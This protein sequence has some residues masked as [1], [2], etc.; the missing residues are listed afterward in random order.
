M[1]IIRYCIFY[2]LFDDI[3]YTHDVYENQTKRN[4]GQYGKDSIDW[5]FVG[6]C[7]FSSLDIGAVHFY[8]LCV[9]FIHFQKKNIKVVPMFVIEY[10]LC[11]I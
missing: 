6:A 10:C 2:E 1:G 4:R 9:A 7:I 5:S 8:L 11:F 3:E